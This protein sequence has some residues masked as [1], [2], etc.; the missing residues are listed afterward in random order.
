[1]VLCVWSSIENKW[2]HALRFAVIYGKNV[3]FTVLNENI[4]VQSALGKAVICPSI[5]SGIQPKPAGVN[6]Q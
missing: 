6:L 2:Y 3:C 4:D 1:M 5:N